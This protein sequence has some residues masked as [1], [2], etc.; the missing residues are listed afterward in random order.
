MPRIRLSTVGKRA[1]PVSGATV[2]N[3]LPPHVTSAPSLAIVL[4]V[5]FGHSHLTHR[6]FIFVELAIIKA[7]PTIV[8]EAFIFY[9]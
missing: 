9:L 5:L 8:G 6:A 2:W 3:D 7:T 1:F 4:A